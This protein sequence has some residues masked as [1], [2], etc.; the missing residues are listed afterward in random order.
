MFLVLQIAFVGTLYAFRLKVIKNPKP[1]MIEKKYVQLK[2]IRTMNPDLGNGEYLFKPFSLTT[3]GENVYIYDNLQA[4]LIKLDKDLNF[5]KSYGRRGLGPGD[6]SGTGKS[7]PVYIKFGRDG[8]LY[9]HDKRAMRISVFDKD[10]NYIQDHVRLPFANSAPVVDNKGN[11]YFFTVNQDTTTDIIDEKKSRITS[12]PDSPK[13]FAFLFSKPSINAPARA[14]PFMLKQHVSMDI[15]ANSELL[16]YYKAF[17]A[18]VVV[19]E[20][21]IIRTKSLW[22][23]D[24]FNYYKKDLY[25][26]RKSNKNL[27][28]QLFFKLFLDEDTPDA[29]Y[30]QYGENRNRKINVVYKF[31]LKGDLL[32]VFYVDVKNSESFSRFELK[33]HNHF[34]VVEDTNLTLYK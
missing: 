4:K 7:Y 1:N 24:A 19:K 5:I 8:L 28:R 29:F 11:K 34:Y 30:L 33:K 26:I 31:N 17:S 27:F 14:V 20:G 21:K 15:T 6:F 3:D 13:Y 16:V 32:N 23:R 25:E 2:K 22:P 12:L 10:L 18:M 9:A